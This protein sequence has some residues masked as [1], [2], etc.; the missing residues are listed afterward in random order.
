MSGSTA[1]QTHQ[2]SIHRPIGSLGAALNALNRLRVDE[3]AVINIDARNKGGHDAVSASQILSQ[4]PVTTP[5]LY[6]GG[7]TKQT[8]SDVTKNAAADRYILSSALLDG[9]FETAQALSEIV[10]IQATVGCL[11]FALDKG[12][13]SVFHTTSGQ[14]RSLSADLIARIYELCDEVIWYDTTKDGEGH[15]FDRRV[16]DVFDVPIHRSIICGGV[17][18]GEMKWAKQQAF[19]AVY[20]ENRILH[21]EQVVRHK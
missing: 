1:H 16:F 9:D 11:P 10:G 17:G 4:I 2:W 5:L 3:I 6:G 7:I 20:I 18:A 13:V 12:V 14:W 15:G 19:S 8:V 21:S